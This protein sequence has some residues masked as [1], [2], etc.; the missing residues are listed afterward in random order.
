MFKKGTQISTI[1]VLLV[2]D[3]K[4]NLFALE[5]LLED[6]QNEDLSFIQCTS[7]NEALRVALNNEIALILLDVQMPG[8]DGYEVAR[9]MRSEQPLYRRLVLVALTGRTSQEDIERACGCGFDLH[10]SKPVA[11]G[12]LNHLIASL[13]ELNRA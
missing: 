4:E 10:L 7:G 1:N 2:D 5:K 11:L 13:L 9:I 3:K 6:D 8:I 12:A